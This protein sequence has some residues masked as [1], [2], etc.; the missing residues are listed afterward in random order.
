MINLKDIMN[1][2][3]FAELVYYKPE[4]LSVRCNVRTNGFYIYDLTS[5]DVISRPYLA[6]F[7]SFDVIPDILKT[8]F[9]NLKL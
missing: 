5:Y 9:K 7:F 1:V 6:G 2:E 4:N 3:D 8:Q